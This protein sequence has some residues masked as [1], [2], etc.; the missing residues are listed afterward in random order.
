MKKLLLVA[1]L[2]VA[3]SSVFAQTFYVGGS[4]GISQNKLW[5]DPGL[6]SD[7]ISPSQDKRDVSVKALVGY[8]INDRF[9]V[10]ASFTDLGKNKAT[11]TDTT[12]NDDPL[13]VTSK[14][15]ATTIALKAN[16]AKFDQIT[17]FVKVGVTRLSNK[18]TYDGGSFKNNKNNLYY[19]LGADYDLTK[20]IAL[21]AEYENYGK[22]GSF[23]SATIETN[24]TGVKSSALSLGVI[25]KF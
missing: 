17:P 5:V 11:Y 13:N 6:A 1:A 25:Y 19:A 2:S 22:A 9:A 23:D 7:D 24:A 8:N 12:G 10:E 14:F 4:L 18:E 16:V 15:K 20:T 3:A 21:R